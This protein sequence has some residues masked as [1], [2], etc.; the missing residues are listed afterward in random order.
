MLRQKSFG[1]KHRFALGFQAGMCCEKASASPLVSVFSATN[2][3]FAQRINTV[4]FSFYLT[5][6]LPLISPCGPTFG[7]STAHLPRCLVVFIRAI[8]GSKQFL[9]SAARMTSCLGGWDFLSATR[10]PLLF[11]V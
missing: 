7:C 9:T 4:L 5:R 11:F 6:S 3:A 10:N 1:K 8:R 2:P